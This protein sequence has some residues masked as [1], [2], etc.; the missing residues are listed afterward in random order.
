MY[1]VLMR[2]LVLS[3]ILLLAFLLRVIGISSHPVGFTPDEASW[4]YDAY[5]L[6]KTG[7]D[8]WGETFPFIMRSFG[9]FKLPLYAYLTVP[10]IAIFGLNEFAVR[11]PNAVFGTMAVLT[12]YLVV[13][14]LLG[15]S[16]LKID[17]WKL[18]ILASFLLAVSPWHISLS[19]GAFEANLATFF[20]PLGVWLFLNGLEKPRLMTA[21]S[22]AFGLGLF[23][24]H[25]PR[26][27]IP[28]LVGALILWNRRSLSVAKHK[29]AGVVFVVFLALAGY[30]MFFG[31]TARG[32]D[33]VISNPTDRWTSVAD[34][35][36]EAVL[37]GVP[38]SIARVFSNKAVYIFDTF[39]A[40]Y[41]S[42]FS[43]Q[44][45]FTHGAAEWTYG[46][47]PGRGVVYLIE[48]PFL[49]AAL[50]YLMRRG[51]KTDSS[52]KF[53]LAWLLLAA[54]PAAFAKG[55]GYAANRA[56]VIMPAIQIFSAYGALTLGQLLG[57]RW[58]L[59]RRVWLY[60]FIAI[61]LLSLI[62]F[63]EDYVYHAPRHA[64]HD[65]L[66]GVGQTIKFTSSIEKNYSEIIVSRKISEP[67]V[68]VAFYKMWDPA[69]YQAASGDWLRY[70]KEGLLFV[71]QL[72]EYKLGKYTFTSID[73][74][75]HKDRSSILLVGRP[76]EFPSNIMPLYKVEYLDGKDAIWV[77]NAR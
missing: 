75:K 66:Y 19:R 12:T 6:L 26:V 31:A 68:Y 2:K 8:Q 65:M 39:A 69:D 49:L 64:A 55:P 48:L 63:L 21:A 47:I 20:I 3:G 71:D 4:G 7:R 38:D 33:V 11:F 28:I 51:I 14:R 67:H 58:V 72:G 74:V 54:L 13:G 18:K 40:S 53:L 35:R 27:L 77:V 43:P 30:T 46:M 1:N 41:L 34:R 22:F 9:D 73:F 59:A 62:V 15:K 5:S 70:E 76:E 42:Y 17:N 50:W 29:I 32:T 57:K 56:A 23:S 60:G 44:F 36:Y 61:L 45:L 10:S 25:A 52:L 16:D 24:Y 37:Q